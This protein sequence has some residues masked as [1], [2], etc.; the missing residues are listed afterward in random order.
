MSLKS[1]N[2]YLYKLNNDYYKEFTKTDFLF[3]CKYI[4]NTQKLP[5]L[6]LARAKNRLLNQK[7]NYE[8]LSENVT[9]ERELEVQLKKETFRSLQGNLRILEADADLTVPMQN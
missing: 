3:Q 7:I 8:L 9:R 1:E 4:N 6:K 2:N 5:P